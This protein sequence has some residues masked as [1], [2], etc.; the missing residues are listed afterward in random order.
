M[1]AETVARLKFR[2][3]KLGLSIETVAAG[4]EVTRVTLWRWEKKDRPKIRKGMIKAWS[5]F[6]TAAEKSANGKR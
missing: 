4:I 2:R 5:D 1:I 6:L 3:E